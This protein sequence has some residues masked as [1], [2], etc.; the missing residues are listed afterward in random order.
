MSEKF[1]ESLRLELHQLEEQH[2]LRRAGILEGQQ[3]HATTIDGKQVIMLCSNNYLGLTN[4]PRVIKETIE[5][6]EKYG[7][8]LGC[9]RV[10]VSM[11]VQLELEKEIAEFKHCE[12][13]ITFQTGYDTN[14]AAVWTLAGEG[15]WIISD[16]LNHAS[17]I[18]G[19]R[20]S[21]AT[22]KV[23]P[24]KDM[25]GLE[26]ILKESQGARR[27]IIITDSVF[28]MDGDIAPLPEI[29]EL[30][31][32]YSAVVYTDDSHAVGVLGKTGAGISEH[33]GLHGKVEIEMGTLSKALG[34]VGGY[35][36]GSVALREYLF[37]K[38]RPF[39]FATGHLAPPS[40]AAALA[41]IKV[42]HDE[43]Y[44]LEQLWKNARRFRDGLK[45]LGFNT[46]QSETPIIPVMVG[47]AGLATELRN[48]LVERKIFV[49]AFVYPVVAS[50]KAR[51]R[52]IVSA[53]HT[54]D[55]LDRALEVFAE[56][57][58]KLKIIN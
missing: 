50:D 21:P 40:A 6:I 51:L 52:T 37:Q 29:V 23:F 36:A 2:L 43:P 30:A 8:G 12:A 47:D 5:A 56:C 39:V 26:K 45:S 25:A 24:H 3:A 17:I 55:E 28:S 58:H 32:K 46:G 38:A 7:V 27:K 15:D 18:D 34:S 14:L 31:E 49:Q 16:S 9:G 20:L 44:L 4:H 35:V 1:Q 41:A 57:G 33:F 22:K 53:T 11:E 13:S 19:S 54:S 48:M 10:I 42:L